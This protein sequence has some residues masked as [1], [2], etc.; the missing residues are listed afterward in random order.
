MNERANFYLQPPPPP[1]VKSWYANRQN[2]VLSCDK[3][4]ICMEM[5]MQKT[6]GCQQFLT[7]RLITCRFYYS[8]LLKTFCNT[9][10]QFQV[11]S[12]FQQFQS[13]KRTIAFAISCSQ[14]CLK[15]LQFQPFLK[16]PSILDLKVVYIFIQFQPSK[17]VIS[18]MI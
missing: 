16:I 8:K 11:S 1:N 17:S 14:S 5:N 13:S 18:R 2:L 7:R 12:T 3:T 15:C 9:A 10:P 6:H 4:R